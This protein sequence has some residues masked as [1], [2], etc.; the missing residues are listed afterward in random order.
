MQTVLE[1]IREGIKP[2]FCN[3]W[4]F[5]KKAYV[6]CFIYGL[7]EIIPILFSMGLMYLLKILGV[8]V[9]VYTIVTKVALIIG[10]IIPAAGYTGAINDDPNVEG[11]MDICFSGMIICSILIWYAL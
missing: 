5:I 1:S 3:L 6:F 11:S 10:Q 8:P 4:D 9:D 2:L 7:F